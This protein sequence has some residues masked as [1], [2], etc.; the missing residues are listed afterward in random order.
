M[1]IGRFVEL[2]FIALAA[3]NAVRCTLKPSVLWLPDGRDLRGN[4][5]IAEM[6]DDMIDAALERGRVA[7]THECRAARAT[8]DRHS[9]HVVIEL[10]NGCV[11]SFP[12]ALVEALRTAD[13][14]QIAAVE[15]LGQGYGLHWEALDLDLSVTGLMAG[16]FSSRGTEGANRLRIGSALAA[17]SREAGLTNADVEALELPQT[18]RTPS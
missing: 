9:R 10:T 6:T 1:Q 11:F 3:Q 8:Y 18:S 2:W 14:D 5:P 16:R 17:L 15:I 7:Q 4:I 13:Y 12:S